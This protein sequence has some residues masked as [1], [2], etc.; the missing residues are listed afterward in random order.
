MLHRTFTKIRNKIKT[1]LTA[2][3]FQIRP[4]YLVINFPWPNRACY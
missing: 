3:E 1:P 2:S 4:A